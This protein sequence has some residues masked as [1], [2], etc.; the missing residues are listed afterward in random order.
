MYEQQ[1]PKVLE[2][3]KKQ[4]DWRRK[5]CI[6]L[7][8]SEN[9]MSPLAI[10]VFNSDMMHRYAEGLPYKRHYQGT[11]YVDEIEAMVI[12]LGRKLFRCKYFDSRPISGMVANLCVFA[13]LTQPGD[14]IANLKIPDGGHISHATIG[15]A[16]VRGL[17]ALNMPF[18]HEEM[19]IDVERLKPLL[20]N[21]KVKLVI[22]GGSLFLFPHPVKEI[23]EILGDAQILYDASHV[24]GLIAGKK[25]QDPLREGADV[26]ASSSHKTFPGPQGG[27]V[28]TDDE[29]IS[30]QVAQAILPGMVSNHHLH[31]LPSLA[32]TLLEMLEFGE[33][34]ADQIV[35]NSKKLAGS[36]YELGFTVLC[37]HKG[38]TESHQ[39]VVDVRKNKGGKK[40]AETLEKANIICNKNLLPWDKEEDTENPSG[41]R[42]GVQE[43]TRTGMKESEMEHIANLI[44]RIIIKGEKPEKVRDEGI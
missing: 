15:T 40:V 23:R 18:D 28:F 34:Y 24:L 41:I 25:F 31:R 11:K 32:I 1:L 4:D 37:E 33:K 42:L 6:N 8:A 26:V 5:E 38:F 2:I 17:K 22:L 9:I 21:E 36:L 13:A 44:A 35:K 39:V 29:K 14:K 16:G 27:M 10:E 20:K 7:I 12:D 43:C 3:V 30:K 19:N